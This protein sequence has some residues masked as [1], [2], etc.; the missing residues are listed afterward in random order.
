M[1]NGQLPAKKQIAASPRQSD[2]GTV[3]VAIWSKFLLT[4]QT[5]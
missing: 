4:E 2:D 3:I 1:R 5:F